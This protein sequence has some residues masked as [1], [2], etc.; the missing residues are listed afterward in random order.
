MQQLNP[1]EL[2]LKSSQPKAWKKIRKVGRTSSSGLRDGAQTVCLLVENKSLECGEAVAEVFPTAKYQRCRD[3]AKFC[4]KENKRL[5][6]T[7]LKTEKKPERKSFIMEKASKELLREFVNSQNFT[8]TTDIFNAMK[9]LFSD[10]LQ[11]V[12]EAELGEK[13]GYKKTS[14]C[15]WMTKIFRRKIT[16]TGTRKRA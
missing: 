9:E 15:R 6:Q 3:P 5:H 12:I 14:V 8:S 7:I 11:Q 10:V 4:V 13:L 16:E 2:R 1:C